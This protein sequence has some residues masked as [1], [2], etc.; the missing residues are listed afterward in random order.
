MC[1]ILEDINLV[2]FLILRKLFIKNHLKLRIVKKQN[3][4]KGKNKKKTKKE[5]N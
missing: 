2:F 4:G 3:L 5:K 1:L